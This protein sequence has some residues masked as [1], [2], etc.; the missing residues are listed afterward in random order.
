VETVHRRQWKLSI[1]GSG[2]NQ[3]PAV[4][5][6]NKKEV[7]SSKQLKEITAIFDSLL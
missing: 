4:E 1:A 7:V 6:I 5:R 2:S 3:Q